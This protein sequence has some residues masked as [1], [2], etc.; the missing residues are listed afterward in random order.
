MCDVF[1]IIQTMEA[2]AGT[3]HKAK[4]QEPIPEGQKAMEKT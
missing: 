4:E 2:T 3:E 1:S